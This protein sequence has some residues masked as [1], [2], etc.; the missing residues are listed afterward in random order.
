[1]IKIHSHTLK[2]KL[3]QRQLT[4]LLTLE[5]IAWAKACSNSFVFSGSCP[6]T[7]FAG[8]TL[9][10]LEVA[11]PITDSEKTELTLSEHKD[12]KLFIRVCQWI[13]YQ[14]HK[15]ALYT[16]NVKKLNR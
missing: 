11:A 3:N 14:L 9:N 2:A 1:M 15:L 12:T 16:T 5:P 8:F 7:T 13:L 10:C 6:A 4:S